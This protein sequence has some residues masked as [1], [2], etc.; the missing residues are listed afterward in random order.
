[1]AF[2]IS[3]HELQ[4]IISTTTRA[5]SV[6]KEAA[7]EK[8]VF[9]GFQRL[10][11]AY[12]S[13]SRAFFSRANT[14]KSTASWKIQD[15]TPHNTQLTTQL[16]SRKVK[17]EEEAGYDTTNSPDLLDMAAESLGSFVFADWLFL[18]CSTGWTFLTCPLCFHPKQFLRIWCDKHDLFIT[19]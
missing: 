19:C 16:C 7:Q 15:W 1:M 9:P 3:Q 18:V 5:E 14:D 12:S 11:E 13:R 6:R 2:D 17:K 4:E 10:L 8:E